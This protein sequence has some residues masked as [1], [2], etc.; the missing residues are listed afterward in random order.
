ME[1]E[2]NKDVLHP[3]MSYKRSRKDPW[4]SWIKG[5]AAAAHED[6]GWGVGSKSQKD[7]YPE[8]IQNISRTQ[9]LNSLP[10]W[11]IWK[12]AIWD[13]TMSQTYIVG[14]SS[15]TAINR[16]VV[17]TSLMFRQH[18]NISNAQFNFVQ[19]G[20]WPWGGACASPTHAC[21]VTQRFILKAHF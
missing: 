3:T 7:T 6:W 19:N 18:R 9:S 1:I 16:T 13:E 5:S 12:S 4:W 21:S 11:P 14:A 2:N 8:N 15:T 17:Q 10:H 20:C